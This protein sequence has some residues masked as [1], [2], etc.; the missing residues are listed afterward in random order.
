VQMASAL[1]RSDAHA[2]RELLRLLLAAQPDRPEAA[3]ALERL[4]R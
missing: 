3:R 2:A 1:G 4:G